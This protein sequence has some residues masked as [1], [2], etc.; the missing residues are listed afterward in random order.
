MADDKK[1]PVTPTTLAVKCP[2]SNQPVLDYGTYFYFPG[3]PQVYCDKERSGCPISV[4][5]YVRVLQGQSPLFTFISKQNKP[6]E[7]KLKLNPETK[8]F[9]FDFVPKNPLD[10]LCPKTGKPVDDRETYYQF[11]GYPNVRCWKRERNRLMTAADY[12]QVFQNPEGVIFDN[13]ISHRTS[14]PFSARLRFNAAENKFD[15]VFDERPAGSAPAP[16][17]APKAAPKADAP[18]AA[19]SSKPAVA[20]TAKP[21]KAEPKASAASEPENPFAGY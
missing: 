2:K 21:A 15:L 4:Q 18:K 7:A 6:F 14:K 5:D 20:P 8:R 12:V 9:E 19:S 16:K 11:P 17:P 1:Q 13:F 10:T 3:F